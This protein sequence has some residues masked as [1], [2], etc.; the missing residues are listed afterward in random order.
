MQPTD[1][2]PFAT[3]TRHV[4]DGTDVLLFRKCDGSQAPVI[5]LKQAIISIQKAKLSFFPL[6]HP[7]SYFFCELIPSA[8]VDD[9][10]EQETSHVEHLLRGTADDYF[11]FF[12][13]AG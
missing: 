2:L 8:F 10:N 4:L 12:E 9:A 3:E 5:S 13:K 7:V 6:Q 11:G 1:P